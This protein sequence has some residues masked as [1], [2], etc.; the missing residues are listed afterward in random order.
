M[1]DKWHKSSVRVKRMEVASYWVPEWE[2][3]QGQCRQQN[4]VSKGTEQG[5]CTSEHRAVVPKPG[6]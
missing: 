4:S 5:V 3:Y 2:K 1:D 6:L